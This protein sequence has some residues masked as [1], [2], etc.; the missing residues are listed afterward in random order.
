MARSIR[1]IIAKA[2]WGRGYTAL[3]EEFNTL[4]DE[5]EELRVQLAAHE[6]AALDAAPSVLTLAATEAK[7]IG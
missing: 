7:K 2:L 5:V 4:V 1:R 6:H 3:R